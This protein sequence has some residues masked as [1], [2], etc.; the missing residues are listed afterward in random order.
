MTQLG[1]RVAWPGLRIEFRAC[2]DRWYSLCI[3]LSVFSGNRLFKK[4]ASDKTESDKQ[5]EETGRREIERSLELNCI[6]LR[7]CVFGGFRKQTCLSFARLARQDPY[8]IVCIQMH[9]MTHSDE[10]MG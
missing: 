1:L 10:G 3:H 4:P 6:R 5:E 2:P 7:S 8:G 9:M